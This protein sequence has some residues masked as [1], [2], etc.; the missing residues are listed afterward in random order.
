[1]QTLLAP[2]VPPLHLSLLLLAL[3]LLLALTRWR[4]SACGL[5]AAGLAWSLV[6]SLPATSLWLGGWL[7]EAAR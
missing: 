3:A 4:R 2:L 5:A 7:E 1:M 6:W